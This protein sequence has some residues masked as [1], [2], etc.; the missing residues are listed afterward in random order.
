MLI[1]NTP[2]DLG[3]GIYMLGTPAYPLYLA[4]GPTEGVIIEGGISAVGPLVAEQL[5]Q[6]GIGSGYVRQAVIT[7]AHPD[8]VMAIP[9]LRELFPGL[10][11]VAS[12]AAA[13]ALGSEKAIDFFRKVDGA[14]TEA[15][16]K[17][18]TLASAP[19]APALPE[20][21]IAV[22]QVVREGDVVT[23][24]QRAWNVLETPGHSDCSISL[25]D[26][27]EG[28]LVI[29]DAAGYYMPATNTWWP[30]YFSSY[31]A[32]LH[33][34]ERLAQLDARLLCLSH[35]AA[36]Q[37]C[38]DIK[39]FFAGALAA[40]RLYHERIIAETKAGKPMR[41]LAEELGA[42]IHP[43][44]PMLPLDFFQKNC[45][46]MVKQSL[47]HEADLEGTASRSQ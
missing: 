39:A 37:G 47:K 46:L 12:A 10:T 21:R 11:V 25:Y 43:R 4:C 28:V 5:R 6:L 35:N 26:P 8:H 42:E 45:G 29:S 36:V 13:A 22:D 19:A 32:Y 1:Q 23:L 3:S 18:G 20:S 17:N 15:L 7:H 30:N 2:A 27:A 24:A 16:C 41:Q 40:T 33:S 34:L 31:A 44:T 14:L 9:R 38:E